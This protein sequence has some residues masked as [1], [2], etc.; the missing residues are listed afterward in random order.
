MKR[1]AMGAVGALLLASAGV[2]WWQGRAEVERGAP[3][4]DITG[5]G[6]PGEEVVLPSAGAHGRGAALPGSARKLQSKEE[7]RFARLDRNRNG[8]VERNEML[9]TRVKAFQKL[10]ANHDNLLSF[11][12]WAVKT[13]NRFK[14]IDRNG[15]GIV[16]RAEL[17]AYYAAKDARAAA[18][19][20][21][22]RCGC[23]KAGPPVK[24]KPPSDDDGDPAEER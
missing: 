19:K 22:P 11:E 5:S 7:K 9:A 12:E 14:E 2:F 21:A 17:D 15:D 16:T 10:D 23:G 20:A 1:V 18:R 6:A 13:A 8:Q 4:P 3:P 24:G